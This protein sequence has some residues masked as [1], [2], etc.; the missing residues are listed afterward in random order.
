VDP[1]GSG[2][3]VVSM[4]SSM[5]FPRTSHNTGNFPSRAGIFVPKRAPLRISRA[6]SAGSGETLLALYIPGVAGSRPIQLPD[7]R[8]IY[9]EHASL[10]KWGALGV[11]LVDY[12]AGAEFRSHVLAGGGAGQ[13]VLKA[14]SAMGPC[15]PRSKPITPL[16]PFKNLFC[17]KVTLMVE[18]NGR[19][20]REREELPALQS[21]R[22]AACI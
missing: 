11:G 7:L 4:S 8:V 14:R 1:L 16:A 15:S 17:D 18:L 6:E 2:A 10:F 13:A 12:A 3:A 9:I 21:E 19:A 20:A 5:G 22:A